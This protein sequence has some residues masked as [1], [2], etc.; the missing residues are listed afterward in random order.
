MRCAVGAKDDK[1]GN[2]LNLLISYLGPSVPLVNTKFIEIP[3]RCCKAITSQISHR[4][5]ENYF[6][7][8]FVKHLP[9]RKVE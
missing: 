4:K 2:V 5:Q 9:Y 1:V 8:F 7:V 3:L 6:S